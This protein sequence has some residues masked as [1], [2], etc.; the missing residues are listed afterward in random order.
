MR[1]ISEKISLVGDRLKAQCKALCPLSTEA[2]QDDS[3][4]I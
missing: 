1:T 2:M 4:L 3:E